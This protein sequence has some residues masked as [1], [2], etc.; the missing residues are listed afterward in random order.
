MWSILISISGDTA[1]VGGRMESGYG[2]AWKVSGI[3]T[4]SNVPGIIVLNK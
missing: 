3:E 2:E 4:I 1:G